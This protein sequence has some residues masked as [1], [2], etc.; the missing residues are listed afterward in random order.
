MKYG[1]VVLTLSLLL[2]GCG[3]DAALTRKIPGV[4]KREGT[5]SEAK[6]TFVSTTTISR[7]GTFSFVRTWNQRPHTNTYAGTWKI[8]NGVMLMT[9]TNRS[10]R[11]PNVP[12]WVGPLEAK[13]IQLDDHQLVE[14]FEGETIKLTR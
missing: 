2:T 9:L 3:R 5:N 7:D 6:D 8:K 13:I 1:F 12:A 11:N 4:W 10:G 14:V